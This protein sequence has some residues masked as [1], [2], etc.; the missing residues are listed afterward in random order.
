MRF[1]RFTLIA[2]V[3]LASGCVVKPKTIHV[4]DEHCNILVRKAVLEPDQSKQ[5]LRCTNEDCVDQLVVSGIVG[6][7]SV[8]V[9]G[10]IV[11]VSNV[12]YWIE[13]EQECQAIN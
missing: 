5:L 8:I 11:M 6:A 4:Y 10:S 12:V 2:G 13:R 1:S 9:A 3:L 7:G